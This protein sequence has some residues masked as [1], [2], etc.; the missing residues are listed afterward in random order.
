MA[1]AMYSDAVMWSHPFVA[2]G[3]GPAHEVAL[4]CLC[5]SVLFIVVG[6]GR[7]SLDRLFFGPRFE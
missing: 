4:I 2:S 3:G 6:L 1:I 7:L 5:I